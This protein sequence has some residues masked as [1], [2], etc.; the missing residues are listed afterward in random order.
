MNDEWFNAGNLKQTRTAHGVITY[1]SLTMVIGGQSAD[2]QPLQTEIWLETIENRI[3]TP[4]LPYN[5]YRDVG[6]FIV[7]VGYCGKT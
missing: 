2:M 7:E 6:L 4:I 1:G 3:T 5:G